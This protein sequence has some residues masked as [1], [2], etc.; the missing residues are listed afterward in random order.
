MENFKLD[1]KV[2]AFLFFMIFSPLVGLFSW[3]VW[4]AFFDERTHE[5][6]FLESEKKAEFVGKVDTLYRLKMSHNTLTLKT[7]K[8][9]FYVPAA[10]ENKFLVGDSIAKKKGELFVKHYR[11]G[12]LIEILDYHDIAKDMK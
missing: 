3:I 11:G 12:R 7:G 4:D 9:N 6:M 10:W 1:G 5:Q 2:K 8:H